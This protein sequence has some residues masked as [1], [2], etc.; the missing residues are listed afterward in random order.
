MV[1]MGTKKVRVLPD[2]WTQSTND[3]KYSAHF[4]HTI[5]IA[6]GGPLVLTAAPQSGEEKEMTG[7]VTTTEG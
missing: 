6:D 2:F 5:A 3:G 7:V 1:N 4:E